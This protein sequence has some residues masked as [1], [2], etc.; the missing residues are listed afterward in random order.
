MEILSER[1]RTGEEKNALT[2]RSIQM[3]YEVMIDSEPTVGFRW[4]MDESRWVYNS[5]RIYPYTTVVLEPTEILVKL[6]IDDTIKV[7]HHPYVNNLKNPDLAIQMDKQFNKLALMLAKLPPPKCVKAL[8][9]AIKDNI[10]HNNQY[11][12]RPPTPLNSP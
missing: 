8:K 12:I 10:R 11:S 2:I 3:C 9:K 1:T 4:D 6:T 7:S 5:L